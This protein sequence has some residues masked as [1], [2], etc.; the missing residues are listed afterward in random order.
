MRELELKK[1]FVSTSGQGPLT[2]NFN[3]IMFVFAGIVLLIDGID[4][5]VLK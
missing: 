4:A 5:V 1:S 3:S 2:I